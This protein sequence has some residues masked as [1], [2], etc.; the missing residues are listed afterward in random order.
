M[1]V[2][3]RDGRLFQGTARQIVSAMQDIAFT[4]QT[5][6][7]SEYIDWVVQNAMR[8]DEVALDVASGTDDE[9]AASLV[10]EMIHAGLA[11]RA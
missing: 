10:A 7:L 5:L 11:K 8:F 4:G 9:R 6:S 2:V 1:K 3:M